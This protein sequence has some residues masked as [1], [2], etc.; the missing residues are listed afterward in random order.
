M[1]QK[2]YLYEKLEKDHRYE[3]GFYFDMAEHFYEVGLKKDAF[4]I[5]LNA[6]EV[7]QGTVQVQQ[8]IAYMLETWKMFGEA[9]NIYNGLL[10]KNK[11]NLALYRNLAWAHYQAGNYQQ[12]VDKLYAAITQQPD[13]AAGNQ[14]SEKASMLYEMNQ[15]IEARRYQLDLSAIPASLIKSVRAEFRIALDGNNYGIGSMKVM[16]PGKTK[17]EKFNSINGRP[18]NFYAVY[19]H[20]NGY[21]TAMI[22]EDKTP[23]PGKYKV[24][25][26]YY[27]NPYRHVVPSFIKLTTFKNFGKVNEVIEVQL[28]N[29]DNQRGKI[30]IASLKIP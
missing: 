23:M 13:A 17:T 15:I 8:A 21:N 4:E 5:L 30:E 1:S 6:A 22:Y 7:N 12:A 25:V 14:A 11:N 24:L 3:A 28:I 27:G 2:K 26:D 29:M 19:D 9:I 10:A 16:G 20:E 18:V